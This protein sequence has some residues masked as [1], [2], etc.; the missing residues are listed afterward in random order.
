MVGGK[1][2]LS[3][4]SCPVTFTCVYHV[5]CVCAYAQNEQ[6]EVDIVNVLNAYACTPRIKLTLGSIRDMV[7][8]LLWLM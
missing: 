2:E 6:V 3:F 5:C 8:S 1:K 7:L 4:V